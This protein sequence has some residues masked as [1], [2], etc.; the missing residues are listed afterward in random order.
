[1]ALPCQKYK[2]NYG[3]FR[4]Q[5]LSEGKKEQT[6]GTEQCNSKVLRVKTVKL[7]GLSFVEFVFVP[8]SFGQKRAKYRCKLF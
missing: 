1:M 5:N 4:I 6:K 8:T 3:A 7:T 2:Q